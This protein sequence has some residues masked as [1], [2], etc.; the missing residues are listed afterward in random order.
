M[1]STTLGLSLAN[2]YVDVPYLRH[3]TIQDSD[4]STKIVSTTGRPSLPALGGAL[5]FR[6]PWWTSNDRSL[7]LHGTAMGGYG[8]GDAFLSAF[9]S[10]SLGTA[11][12]LPNY[13]L[14]FSAN[15]GY[16]GWT[17]TD[18][19]ISSAV[20]LGLDAT[21]KL[22]W[23]SRINA[24]IGGQWH[25]HPDNS[26]FLFLMG[27]NYALSERTLPPLHLDTEAL[28]WLKK[29][30][31]DIHVG[32]DRATA[33]LADIQALNGYPLQRRIDDSLKERRVV[34]VFQLFEK[35]K[36][37]AAYLTWVRDSNVNE[38]DLKLTPLGPLL[39]L[40]DAVL[41][42]VEMTAN[43]DEPPFDKPTEQLRQ[44]RE[45]LDH[46]LAQIGLDLLFKS[47][48]SLFYQVR[49]VGESARG[50]INASLIDSAKTQVTEYYELLDLLL[51]AISP[52][53]TASTPPALST[54]LSPQQ[55]EL[56]ESFVVRIRCLQKS[57]K[58]RPVDES[59]TVPRLTADIEGLMNKPNKPK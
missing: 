38:A 45:N 57:E 21:F 53:T 42:N 2:R 14:N 26:Q 10:A 47:E 25:L 58:C 16:A 1:P 17:V 3:T 55:R 33:T 29:E 13:P 9:W 24:T 49:R 59:L 46:N 12:N 50:K 32:L 36:A 40:V 6:L 39:G 37:V 22:P 23:A 44:A 41:K 4:G 19:P 15:L 48:D 11:L 8:K 35:I 27:A 31:V 54:K 34:P 7:T 20:L 56:V 28:T 51:K 43:P 52:T 30:K 5:E 18:H